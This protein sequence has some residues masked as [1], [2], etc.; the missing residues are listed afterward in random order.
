MFFLLYQISKRNNELWRCRKLA[1][2]HVLRLPLCEK[3]FDTNQCED[4][5]F[6]SIEFSKDDYF[7]IHES[8]FEDGSENEEYHGKNQ[9]GNGNRN[10]NTGIIS[11]RIVNDYNINDVAVDVVHADNEFRPIEKEIMSEKARATEST[12]VRERERD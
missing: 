4:N 2:C 11:E 6:T 5:Q 1:S 10:G 9:T 7:D 12:R 8:D 3:D